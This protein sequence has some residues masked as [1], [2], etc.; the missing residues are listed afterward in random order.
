MKCVSYFAAT[1]LRKVYREVHCMR[2][3]VRQA[4]QASTPAVWNFERKNQN[5]RNKYGNISNIRSQKLKMG[6][7]LIVWALFVFQ[8]RDPQP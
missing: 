8:C 1:L 4:S 6:D 2:A 7:F 5:G 3:E